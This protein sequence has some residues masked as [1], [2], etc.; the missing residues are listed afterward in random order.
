MRFIYCQMNLTLNQFILENPN[1][2]STNPLQ[3][4]CMSS[5]YCPGP[6]SKYSG[7]QRLLVLQVEL[8]TGF[9]PFVREIRG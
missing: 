1:N 6:I 5:R 7:S 4:F 9:I 3:E 8:V 2:D